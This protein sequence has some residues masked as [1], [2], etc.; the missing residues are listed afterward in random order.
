MSKHLNA[1]NFCSVCGKDKFTRVADRLS[2]SEVT[3]A[4]GLGSPGT[5]THRHPQF[6]CDNCGHISEVIYNGMYG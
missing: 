2:F 6:R 3:W 4:D 5:M 1:P